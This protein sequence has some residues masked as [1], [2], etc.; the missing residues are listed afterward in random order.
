MAP[1]LWEGAGDTE[2][3]GGREHAAKG[4]S[5]VFCLPSPHP[6]LGSLPAPRSWGLGCLRH[7]PVSARPYRTQWNRIFPVA[8]FVE[9]VL[10]GIE[11]QIPELRELVTEHVFLL[12]KVSWRLRGSR[13]RHLPSWQGDLPPAL[14][15]PCLEV[16]GARSPHSGR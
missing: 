2:V 3:A 10:L 12:N 6:V 16:R 5:G 13:E 9:H 14:C 1:S 15:R 4:P 7:S 8:L 11:S